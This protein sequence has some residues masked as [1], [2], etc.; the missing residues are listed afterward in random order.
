MDDK[1]GGPIENDPDDIAVAEE[2][3]RWHML[4]TAT[5]GTTVKHT[6]RK[7]KEKQRQQHE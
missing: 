5:S 3:T 4:T 7:Q 2:E 6:R 1:H